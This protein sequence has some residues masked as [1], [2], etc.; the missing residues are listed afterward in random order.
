MAI[1]NTT[2][3]KIQIASQP[4]NEFM[5]KMPDS[6]LISGGWCLS[7]LPR[8]GCFISHFCANA[9]SKA[10]MARK[11]GEFLLQPIYKN[12]PMPRLLLFFFLLLLYCHCYTVHVITD[13]LFIYVFL[14]L[15]RRDVGN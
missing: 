1:Y 14:F 3:D 12:D 13:F 8:S 4:E 9:N 6:Q 11:Y 2:S 10:M 7:H 15:Q 5:K